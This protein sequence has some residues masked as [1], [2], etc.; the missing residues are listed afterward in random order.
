MPPEATPTTP[1]PSV[2]A[3]SCAAL[4]ARMSGSAVTKVEP[5]VANPGQS[6]PPRS[7][8]ETG[9]RNIGHNCAAPR[10]ARGYLPAR[11]VSETAQEM[12]GGADA[13]AHGPLHGRGP[14]GGGPRAGQR[15]ARHGV[16]VPGRRAACPGAAAKVACGSFTT[17]LATSSAARARAVEHL[18]LRRGWPRRARRG[19]PRPPRARPRSR[20]P[21]GARSRRPCPMAVRLKIHWAGLSTTAVN[22]SSITGRSYQTCTFTIGEAPRP[23]S[24]GR[25]SGATS[26]AHPRAAGRAPRRRPASALAVA[27]GSR[28]RRRP[29][30]RRGPSGPVPPRAARNVARG[31]VDERA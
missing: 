29:P 30:R 7:V 2:M 15:D 24:P 5:L 8:G 6:R 3:G 26:A 18:E 12:P 10:T 27:P 14:A 11:T 23:G 31:R 9:D 1:C 16:A 4:Q 22:G 17:A 13:A 28:P 19:A 20:R 25:A 21:G